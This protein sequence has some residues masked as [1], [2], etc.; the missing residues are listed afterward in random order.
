M[1]YH[2]LTPDELQS[3]MECRYNNEKDLIR[4]INLRIRELMPFTDYEPVCIIIPNSNDDL[5]RCMVKMYTDVGWDIDATNCNG[6]W[7]WCF[8]PLRRSKC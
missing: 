3:G 5:M 6:R 1:E 4:W 2:P 7:T 8:K